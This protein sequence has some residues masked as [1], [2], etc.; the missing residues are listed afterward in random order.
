MQLM[1]NYTLNEY[2]IISAKRLFDKFDK[3][4]YIKSICEK[5]NEFMIDSKY[6]IKDI[7]E[8]IQ[9][10]NTLGE[11]CK[12]DKLI[13]LIKYEN[14]FDNVK[15]FNEYIKNYTF[16]PLNMFCI[17]NKKICIESFNKF[18][19]IS[20]NGFSLFS[21]NKIDLSL[22]DTSIIFNVINEELIN[23]KRN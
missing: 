6:P 14:N 13:Y 20:V 22:L 15:D 9:F 11:T 1:Y 7:D 21:S 5:D 19:N 18:F 17:N 8:S 3:K 23:L 16:L 4:Y 12:D 10:I 2:K